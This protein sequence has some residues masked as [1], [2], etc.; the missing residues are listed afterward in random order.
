MGCSPLPTKD[1]YKDV[2]GRQS[3]MNVYCVR[4]G[5][6]FERVIRRN[7]ETPLHTNIYYTYKQISRQ[8]RIKTNAQV[9]IA[10]L[11]S[12]AGHTR[13]RRVRIRTYTYETTRPLYNICYNRYHY[14]KAEGLV[15]VPTPPHTHPIASVYPHEPDTDTETDSSRKLTS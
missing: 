10:H 7:I 3:Y 2:Q 14:Q 5:Y 15:R 4:I 1:L 13:T 8:S 9:Q 6:G 11:S 12:Q